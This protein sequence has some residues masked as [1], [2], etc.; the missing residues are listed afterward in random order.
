MNLMKRETKKSN[1]ST[2]QSNGRNG[3]QS[4]IR[5]EMMREICFL[6]S[7]PMILLGV[8][9]AFLIFRSTQTTLE[10]SMS[11]LA[12]VAADKVEERLS[13]LEN[14]AIE[15]GYLTRLSNDTSTVADKQTII[16]QRVESHGFRRGDILT[17]DGISVFDGTN[18]SGQEYFQQARNGKTW[19]SDPLVNEAT[20]EL[21][22][23][24]AA[25]IWKG[26]IP[27]STVVGVVYFVPQETF[28]NDIVT[29]IKV[30]EN[31]CAFLV[32]KDGV[33]IANE[34]IEKVKSFD[35]VFEHAKTDESFAGFAA[36][37]K[38]MIN[39]ESGFGR[40]TY[41]GVTK[42][43]SYAPLEGTNGWSIGV[44]ASVNDFMDS[45]YQGILIT[46]VLIVV[47]IIT[48]VVITIRFAKR[49]GD[50][51]A[52]CT[53]RLELMAH[54]DLVSPVPEIRSRNETKQLAETM[55]ALIKLQGGTLHQ[56]GLT[57]DQMAVGSDQ[58]SASAQSLSQGATEQAS[59]IEELASAISVISDQVLDTSKNSGE[60]RRNV[61]QSCE[62]MEQCDGQMKEMVSAMSEISNNSQQIGRIIKTIEDIAFQTSILALNAAVEAARAGEAGRGFAVV[63]DEVQ[64]LAGKT[65]AASKDTAVLIAAAVQSVEKGADIANAT[66]TTMDSVMENSKA[67]AIMVDKIAEAA[68][69]QSVSITQVSQG[70]NQISSVV[71]TNSSA[72]EEN[73]VSSEEMSEHAKT[74][75]KLVSQFKLTEEKPV[76]AEVVS[77]QFPQK[78]REHFN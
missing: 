46:A 68:E 28:L 62:M 77:I 6:V 35:S 48:A 24:V 39:G 65:A 34:D 69:Q 63:A 73:A 19:V 36:L 7:I 71:Q 47:T 37:E 33:T 1:V 29:E 52:K 60:A 27:N 54:G 8:L 16:D 4:T 13:S 12:N 20:D 61:D 75:R 14:I 38:K 59:T 42:F 44:N 74:L 15:T 51:V 32:N 56:I 70:I 40:Y 45:T 26:G 3:K 31:A 58:V 2:D 17:M 78:F 43:L 64:N 30:S 22:V 67:A 50:P 5:K 41:N 76:S 10:Q 23:V 21:T 55:A 57:A 49:I 11:Q 9:A 18:F 53:A 66:A 72:A 25:P